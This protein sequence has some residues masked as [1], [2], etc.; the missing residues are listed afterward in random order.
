M[1]KKLS[2]LLRTHFSSFSATHPQRWAVHRWAHAVMQCRTAALGGHV[3]RCPEGHMERV[4]YNSCKHRA[5]PQCSALGT[6]QW[7]EKTFEKLL[8]DCDYYHVIF[9]IPHQLNELWQWNRTWLGDQLLAASRDT[10]LELLRDPKWLG[11]TPGLVLSLH[12]WGRNLSIHPHVH[13]LVTGGG[14][15]E[16]GWKGVRYDYLLPFQVVRALFRGKLLARVKQGIEAKELLIPQGQSVSSLLNL[17]HQL[18]RRKW[19]VHVRT[20]Y[21]HGR[22]VLTYLAR[23]VRGGPLKEGQL[24]SVSSE[25][26]VFGHTDHRDGRWK[27]LALSMDAF[28]QRL[29]AH[30]PEPG[31]RMIRYAGIYAPGH[32]A[33]LASCRQDLGMAPMAEPD[34]LTAQVYLEGLGLKERTHCPVCGRRLIMDELSV[35]TGRSPPLLGTYAHAA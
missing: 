13:V 1:E 14:W 19:N 35:D 12:T 7:L 34:Y 32:R 10:L 21:P 28:L 5:C 25:G 30:I 3:L 22:G 33:R 16:A 27:R 18:G 2:S 15:M 9:T 17:V 20:R 29:A 23:Y 4:Q 6:E 8:L 26:V 11:A 24:R 31:Y